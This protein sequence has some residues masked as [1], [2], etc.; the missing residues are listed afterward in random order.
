MCDLRKWDSGGAGGMG[1]VWMVKEES[2]RQKKQYKQKTGVKTKQF[3]F[4]QPVKR[5]IWWYKLWTNFMNDIGSQPM[6]PGTWGATNFER[7]EKHRRWA[8]H[9]P[10][11]F[12]LRALSSSLRHHG[13]IKLQREVAF[14][15]SWGNKVRTAKTTENWETNPRE[16]GSQRRD[17]PKSLYRFLSSHWIKKLSRKLQLMSS[18]PQLGGKR[19]LECKI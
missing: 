1:L 13:M 12:P 15:L 10:P 16:K 18:G 7:K 4:S 6:Y 9:L 19:C 2:L 3:M 8:P 11:A 14:F 17:S 5:W